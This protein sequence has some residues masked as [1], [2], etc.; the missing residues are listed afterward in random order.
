MENINVPVLGIVENMSWF[1]PKDHLDEKY[2]IFGEDAGEN[3]SKS[4]N[5]SLLGKIPLIQSIRQSGDVGRPAVLQ[6]ETVVETYYDNFC[7]ELI[8]VLIKKC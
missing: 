2:F 8:V 5:I 1:S 4:L 7:N 6:Q 3:L